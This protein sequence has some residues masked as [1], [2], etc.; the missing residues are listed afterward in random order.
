MPVQK[1]VAELYG[2]QFTPDNL[3]EIAEALHSMFSGS[4]IFVEKRTGHVYFRI[5]PDDTLVPFDPA[6]AILGPEMS[7]DELKTLAQKVQQVLFVNQVAA[8]SPAVIYIE[9]MLEEGDAQVPVH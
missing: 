5:D 6:V 7:I 2:A 3:L 1:V 8:Q 9:D 4:E